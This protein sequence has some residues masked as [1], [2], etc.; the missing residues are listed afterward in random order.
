VKPLLALFADPAGRWRGLLAAVSV[1]LALGWGFLW[2]DGPRAGQWVHRWGY[3]LMTLTV[4]AWLVALARLGWAPLRERWRNWRSREELLA[5]RMAPGGRLVCSPVAMVLGGTLLAALAEPTG[6]KILFDEYVLQATA[7][8]LHLTREI[9][10]MVRAYEIEGVWLPLNHYIDKRPYFFAFLLATAHDLTG[11]RA[12]NVFVLNHALTA[13]L[14]ALVYLLGRGLTGRG[15]AGVLAGWL[16]ASLPLLGQNTN[17]SGMELLNVVMILAAWGLGLLLVARP[18]GCRQD[19]FLLTVVLLAQCRYESALYVPLAGG[20]LLWAWWRER[21]VRLTVVTMAVPLLLLPVAWLHLVF[22][23]NQV[24]WQLPE[25]LSAPFGARHVAGNVQHAAAYLFSV[26]P[27]QSNSIGLSVVGV[28]GL[29]ILAGWWWRG[30]RHPPR[31]ADWAVSGLFAVG[32][33]ANLALLM[34]YFWGQLDDP[35]VARLSLPV[36]VLFALAAAAVASRWAWGQAARVWRAALVVVVV[37]LVIGYGR[38]IPQHAYTQENI[39]EQEIRWEMEWVAARPP[40]P[41]L[42]ITNKTNLAWLLTKTP[43][44]LIN[45][46]APRGEA[47]RFHLEADTFREI[48]VMQRWRPSNETGNY[49]LSADEALPASFRLETLAQRRFGI[50]RATISRLVAVEELAD[51]DHQEERP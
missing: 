17:G 23:E 24:L 41:R 10:T 28:I 9:G 1:C 40:G 48:L 31:R 49:A 27:R 25:D 12:A 30:R 43:A 6:F 42:V 37:G 46:A 51:E 5:W 20:V 45:Q 11:Y 16:L 50:S 3:A 26:N 33:L 36:Q 13:L 4:V 29:L 2:T 39:L 8:Q 21:R 32:I 47:L 18:G 14:L 22:G 19:A 15:E 44:L 35:L 34:H 7:A 38:A